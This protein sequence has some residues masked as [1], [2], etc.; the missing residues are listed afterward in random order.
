[1]F[2]EEHFRIYYYDINSNETLSTWFSQNNTLERRR[3]MH[4]MKEMNDKA[5]RAQN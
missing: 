4:N 5:Q 3:Q 2:T 1:M